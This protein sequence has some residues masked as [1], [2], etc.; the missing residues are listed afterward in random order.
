MH[1]PL[2]GGSIV[3]E[4]YHE[5]GDCHLWLSESD[6]ARVYCRM[7]CAG[8]RGEHGLGCPGPLGIQQGAGGLRGEQ[9]G[10]ADDPA[11]NSAPLL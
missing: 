2:L 10:R 7:R 9:H 1:G 3:K 11:Q 8:A 5:D 6:K 4:Q